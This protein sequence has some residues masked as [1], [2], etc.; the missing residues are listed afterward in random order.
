[1]MNTKV[2]Y[3][4]LTL[5]L[6][7]FVFV[8]TA[9][10]ILSMPLPLGSDA[11]FHLKLAIFLEHGDLVGWWN[12]MFS[13]NH[14]FYP[15][16]YHVLIIP[17]I[18]ADPY[19]GLRVLE[20]SFLPVTFAAIAWITWKLSGPKAALI[21]GLILI[22]SWSF[23][24]GAIQARPES[25]DL[26]LYPLIVWAAV[27]NRRKW[28]SVFGIITVYNHGFAALSN[29]IGIALKKFK[30]TQWRKT[31]LVSTLIILPIIIVGLYYFPGAWKQWSTYTPTENPQEAL[32][33][34]TPWPWIPYY[35]GLTLFGFLFIFR[36][37]KTETET[38]LSWG[39]IGN[40]IMLP[41][42]ADRWLQYSSIPLA[43]LMGMAVSRWHGWK[44]YIILIVIMAVA[45]A[46]ISQF[47]LI[48][49]TKQWWQP[50]E[51]IPAP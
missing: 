21:T 40:L 7:V 35:S 9:H 16:I 41:F 39:L 30:E 31:L 23:L 38:L 5:A 28:F 27:Y 8:L 11:Y 34:T 15:P 17:F 18:A 2:F 4:V 42:W 50:G 26:F 10:I 12:Y 46:Y 37:G 3:S 32:F 29:I 44:L 45:W 14:Y 13:V 49:F 6:C 22:G 33:W 1:M 47:L 43:M 25:I 24:D 51:F 48:S 19:A 36:K 20:M